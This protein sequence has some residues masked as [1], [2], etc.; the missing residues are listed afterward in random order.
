MEVFY[1]E[2]HL[3]DL[4]VGVFNNLFALVLD[5]LIKLLKFFLSLLGIFV[6]LVHQV[7]CQF[8]HLLLSLHDLLIH[9][10]R[11]HITHYKQLVGTSCNLH[12]DLVK[13]DVLRDLSEI[14]IQN[15]DLAI[16][17]SL[18]GHQLENSALFV[19]H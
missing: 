12:V 13:G 14:F 8:A 16:F 3:L 6:D 7:V 15:V 10:D 18:L 9:Y 19:V 17:I 11:C 4:V 2:L 1:A 5:V